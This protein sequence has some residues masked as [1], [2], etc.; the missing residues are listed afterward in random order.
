MVWLP[1]QFLVND[2]MGRAVDVGKVPINSPTG[3]RP[4][5]FEELFSLVGVWV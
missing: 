3:Q 2:N 1:L 5:E 4:P